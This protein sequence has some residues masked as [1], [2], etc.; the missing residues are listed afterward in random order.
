MYKD[1]KILAIVPARGGSK[2]IPNKNIYEV[3]GKPLIAYTLE[4]ARKSKYIDYVMVS[5][6]SDEIAETAIKYGA[7]V[8]FMRPAELALDTSKTIDAIVDC[9]NRLKDMNMKYDVLILLQPTSPLRTFEDIDG[10]LETFYDNQRQGL[11]SVSEVEINPLL[12]RKLEGNKAV[13]ILD[14]SSTVRRQDFD[15]YY[16]VNGAIYINNTDEIDDSTSFND[17]KIAYKMDPAHSLDIDEP[18]DIETMRTI[19]NK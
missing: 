5:T 19:L 8:P 1:N 18:E 11:V 7:R 12:I 10:A 13:P 15:K 9:I 14:K 16:R 17:N 6:D 2:G 3:N 4:Q